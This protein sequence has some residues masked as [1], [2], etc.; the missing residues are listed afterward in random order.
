MRPRLP[1]PAPSSHVRTGLSTTTSRTRTVP[2]SSDLG[3]KRTRISSTR[4]AQSVL[5]PAGLPMTSPR[6]RPAPDHGVTDA[7]RTVTVVPAAFD[8]NASSFFL[9]T[10]LSL[11]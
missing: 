8:A 7:W 5:K 4:N 10:E 9:G 1:P 11:S 3:S 6:T 2:V